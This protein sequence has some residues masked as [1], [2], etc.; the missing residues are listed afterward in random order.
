MA[1]QLLRI[2]IVGA[3]GAAEV[4]LRA[5]A[6]L[7]GG[8]A[9]VVAVAAATRASAEAFARRHGIPEA[10]DDYRALVERDDVDC[11][12]ICCPNDLHHAVALA[13]AAAGKHVIVE[14]P[15]TGYFGA[16]GEPIAFSR[17]VIAR[18]SSTLAAGL[19]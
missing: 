19:G 8:R 17:H 11:V 14:K 18:R 12:D 9:E 5:L 16:D 15:L 13:A 7:R 6:H 4:H 3:R 2:G 1:A 10:L